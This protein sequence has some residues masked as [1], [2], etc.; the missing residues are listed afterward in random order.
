MHRKW[1]FLSEEGRASRLS[2]IQFLLA[3][4]SMYYTFAEIGG[5]EEDCTSAIEMAGPTIIWTRE[6]RHKN[7]VLIEMG[8]CPTLSEFTDYFFDEDSGVVTG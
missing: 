7:A 6:N 3:T 1:P 4:F 2:D 8:K 5:F